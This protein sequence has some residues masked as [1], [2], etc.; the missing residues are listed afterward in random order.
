MVFGYKHHIN[1]FANVPKTFHTILWGFCVLTMYFKMIL[2]PK[3]LI[4][5]SDD[6]TLLADVEHLRTL[7]VRAIIKV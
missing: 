6:P 7:G 4:S 2:V 3:T 5:V 1:P